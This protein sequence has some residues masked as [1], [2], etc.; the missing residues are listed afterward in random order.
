MEKIINGA[1]RLLNAVAGLG[2]V[3]IMVL[4][5]LNILL[6]TFLNRSILGTYEYAGFFTGA[7][8][9]LSLAQCALQSGHI[10]IGLLVDK[11]KP[12]TQ[13]AVSIFTNAIALVFLSLTSY[14]LFLYAKRL[15][16]N[17]EVSLTTEI[18]F[19]PFVYLVAIGL[20]V[21]CLVILWQLIKS[22]QRVIGK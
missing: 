3:L 16:L 17:G 20:A 9:G 1:S 7:V 10:S 6:R 14:H 2:I 19:Y 4:V 12:K 13:A 11:F 5:T 22:W 21:F 8:I 18:P 15:W